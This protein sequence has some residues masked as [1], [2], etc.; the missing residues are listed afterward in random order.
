[1]NAEV[2][3]DMVIEEAAGDEIHVE[4]GDEKEAEYKLERLAWCERL[5]ARLNTTF[6]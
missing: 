5:L 1:M 3:E 2:E 6:R 4:V